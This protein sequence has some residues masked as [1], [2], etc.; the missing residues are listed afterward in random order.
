MINNENINN[1]HREIGNAPVTSGEGRSVLLRR[2][3][4][5]SVERVWNALTQREELAQWFGQVDGQLCTGGSFQVQDNA[6]GDILECDEPQMYKVTWAMGPGMST[7]L[8]LRLFADGEAT[9][10][11][12]EHSTP[13]EIFDELL[14]SYGPGGTIGIGVGWDLSLVALGMYLDGTAF[15]VATWENAPETKEFAAAACDAWGVAA[16][17]AWDIADADMAPAIAF[18]K[19]QYAPES[20]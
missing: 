6:G 9:T 19:A 16:Q 7:E 18:A 8:S 14:N 11:E 2:S 17:N 15:D 12:V 20:H 5:A 1:T 10:V 13:A 4:T 3:Y